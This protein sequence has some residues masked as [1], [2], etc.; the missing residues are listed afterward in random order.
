MDIAILCSLREGFSNVVLESMASGKPVI[1]SN[2]GG[3]PEA[4][5]QDVTGL[6]FEPQEPEELATKIISLLN[7][8]ARRKN[9]GYCARDRIL[10]QFSTRKMVEHYD[11]IYRGLLKAK[12]LSCSVEA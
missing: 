8:D 11:A 10:E 9:M 1:A 4:V 6:L 7:D 5:T 2:V 3:N 12:H